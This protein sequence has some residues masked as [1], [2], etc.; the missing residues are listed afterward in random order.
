MA[1]R[2][3]D[4]R[5]GRRCL[6]E[7]KSVIGSYSE[8]QLLLEVTPGDGTPLWIVLFASGEVKELNLAVPGPD[9]AELFVSKPGLLNRPSY[10]RRARTGADLFEHYHKMSARDLTD[11]AD[12]K[13]RYDTIW[14]HF[15]TNFDGIRRIVW[16]TVAE[17]SR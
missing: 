3:E 1:A 9:V 5:P 6:V 7:L 12:V 2:A 15:G 16:Q 14:Q 11:S 4:F 13:A 8:V 17:L 10:P